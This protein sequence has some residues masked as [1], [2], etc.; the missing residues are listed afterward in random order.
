MADLDANLA[1]QTLYLEVYIND[2]ST[3]LV[4]EFGRSPDGFY[5]SPDQFQGLGLKIPEWT[6]LA[7]GLVRLDDM[8]GLSY[9][10][11]EAAQILYLNVPHHLLKPQL[12]DV[13]GGSQSA[14]D[15]EAGDFGAVLNY[16]FF[17]SYTEENVF[18]FRDYSTLS[19]A[20]EGRAFSEYGVMTSGMLARSHSVEELPHA[21]R[22]DTAWKHENPETLTTYKAG[23]FISGGLD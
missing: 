8:A 10:F 4:A 1:S 11:D 23:D 12:L 5:I 22:L 18:S 14:E 9:S 2:Y 20:F 17:A 19:G 3:N 16:T 21:V 7:D 15:A 6:A 13:S